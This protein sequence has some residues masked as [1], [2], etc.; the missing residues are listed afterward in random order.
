[1][2]RLPDTRIIG[3]GGGGGSNGGLGM[4]Q[5]LGA[6]M[7][8]KE[9]QA[10]MQ[11]RKRLEEDDMAIRQTLQ[12]HDN[13]DDA[14]TALYK[15]GRPM[16]AQALGKGVYEQRKIAGEEQERR[17]KNVGSRLT[18]STQILQ[19][20]Y[21]DNSLKA[22][23]PAI[24]ALAGPVFGEGEDGANIVRQQLGNTYDKTKIENVMKWG[25]ERA[26]QLE[27][28]QKQFENDNALW[29]RRIDGLKSIDEHDKASRES[30]DYWNAEASRIL[31]TSSQQNWD[32]DR[33][34]LL[35]R[36]A[37]SYILKPYG[38]WSE[39]AP[40][41][42]K[43]LGI[44]PEK[45]ESLEM[46]G[47]RADIA[48]ERADI[49]RERADALNKKDKEGADGRTPELTFRIQQAHREAV[50]AL[51]KEI[52]DRSV[53]KRTAMSADDIA[54]RSLEI[55]N[56][57]RESMGRLPIED[58]IKKYDEAGDTKNLQKTLEQYRSVTGGRDPKGYEG[59]IPGA[60]KET[61]KEAPKPSADTG[62]TNPL[63]G[64]VGAV[65]SLF[66]GGE[67][68]PPAP[69]PSGSTALGKWN[70]QVLTEK[71]D[72][73]TPLARRKRIDQLLGQ[74]Q[75]APDPTTKAAIQ[76]E[77]NRIRTLR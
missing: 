14:I 31:S 37:P 21:D 62:S 46:A 50:R 41:R 53:S 27:L 40:E 59:R 64:V 8:L 51:R 44:K 16:A 29:R 10:Q 72:L 43:Q 5:T 75:L 61:E 6:M 3:G 34:G 36:G 11:A 24:V 30:D 49:A 19:G 2:P 55:E 4:F 39:D 54:S 28:E 18:M 35:D 26:K 33:S 70:P 67:S 32:R 12:Q 52:A 73:A 45:R 57:F 58:E 13:P 63:S 74:K 71:P 68:T 42:A 17:I 66:G 56:D 38:P 22:L 77:I 48:R 20:V 76:T 60:A 47:E 9:Q 7:Q 69:T 1:M 65:R 15:Q 25:T 23:T